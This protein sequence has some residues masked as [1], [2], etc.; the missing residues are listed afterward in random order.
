M[1]SKPPT[2]GLGAHWRPVLSGA[3]AEDAR[4]TARRIVGD[5][6]AELSQLPRKAISWRLVNGLAGYAL[7]FDYA[8]RC[9]LEVPSELAAQLILDGIRCAENDRD[10]SLYF[11][12]AGLAWAGEVTGA[13]TDLEDDLAQDFDRQLTVMLREPSPAHAH[14]LFRGLSGLGLY[15]LERV[16]RTGPDNA[17]M[18]VQRLKEGAINDADGTTWS[19]D[20]GVMKSPGSGAS[21]F[22][23]G[24]P[25]G[26]LAVVSFLA[27]AARAKISGA[28][29][30]LHS[31]GR[32]L[33]A[34]R[35]S[36][37]PGQCF[38]VGIDGPERIPPQRL[39]W[40][41]GE[42]PVACALLQ[43]GIAA[44]EQSWV[45][46]ATEVVLL[47]ASLPPF[48]TVES[49]LCHGNSGIG[50]SFAYL[51]NVLGAPA[52]GEAS[53]RWF[54]RTLKRGVTG[55][56]FESYRALLESPW[57]ASGRLEQQ[58]S[59]S[60]QFLR[61]AGGIALA[62]LAASEPRPPAW[63]AALM[64]PWHGENVYGGLIA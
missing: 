17:A 32:W 40:C 26:L 2:T 58:W 27:S 37:R 18:I 4:D 42:L 38:P 7:L 61:G 45:D 57:S 15:A 12:L 54:A 1:T 31:S 10:P 50:F 64:L 55:Q 29:E 16:P 28:A 3:A 48:E 41:N 19:T 51:Y 56:P 44:E 46:T 25:Q 6:M 39:A 21:W 20:S 33:H 14:S 62:L 30:L 59:T 35:M 23:M 22:S 60:G 8:H 24:M 11:G 63:A 49:S 13:W 47:A 52:L 9:G 34:Q 43:A 36:D 53:A 5:L